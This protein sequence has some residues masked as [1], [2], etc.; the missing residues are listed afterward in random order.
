M[1]EMKNPLRAFIRKS[2]EF[3]IKNR[4]FDVTIVCRELRIRSSAFLA[5]QDLFTNYQL[6]DHEF[7][8]DIRINQL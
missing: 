6:P 3:R 7:G 1:V 4:K 5:L 2:N 8:Y